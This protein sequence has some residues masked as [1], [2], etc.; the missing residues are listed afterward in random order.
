MLHTIIS[1]SPDQDHDIKTNRQVH[2]IET[3]IG[4]GRRYD[5]PDLSPV[6]RLFRI[7]QEILRPGLHLH[8]DQLVLLHRHD[9]QLIMMPMPIGMKDLESPI[10]EVLPG[11]RLAFLP[12]VIS[13]CHTFVLGKGTN[14]YSFFQEHSA[15]P[16]LQ[17]ALQ[18]CCNARAVLPRSLCS[19]TAKPVQ[20][21]FLYILK[22][23]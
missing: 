8:H 20:Y 3:Y 21:F 11:N 10:R 17:P 18:Y 5:P 16:V 1:P 19:E 9:I 22:K 12:Y 2:V 13:F 23:K 14:Y 6:Y 15:P 4:I 7:Y